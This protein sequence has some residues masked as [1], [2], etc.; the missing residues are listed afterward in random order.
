M[1]RD[2]F[3]RMVAAAY[4]HLY[5]MPFLRNHVLASLIVDETPGGEDAG[6]RLHRMLLDEIERLSPGQSAPVDSE[7]WR[8]YRLLY[9]HYVEGEDPQAVADVL[10]VTRRHFF[11][12]RKKALRVVADVLW[13]RFRDRIETVAMHEASEPVQ[14]QAL[15]LLRQ[16]AHRLTQ[17]RE[18]VHIP[19]MLAR[20]CRLCQSLADQRRVE[21][22]TEPAVNLPP[23]HINETILLHVLVGLVQREV[24]RPGVRMIR[25]S[26]EHTPESVSIN[27]HIHGGPADSTPETEAEVRDLREL[28]AMEGITLHHSEDAA[29]RA[30]HLHLPASSRATVL[31]VDDNLDFYH[32]FRRCLSGDGYQVI[33]PDDPREALRMALERQPDVITLDLM[34]PGVEGLSLLQRLRTLPETKDIPVIVCTVLAEKELAL[35]LGAAYYLPKPVTREAILAALSS[36][37]QR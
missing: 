6:W 18:I 23:V 25:L 24:R 30:I 13:E 15:A 28:G 5:D 1:S 35:S 22:R 14:E 12:L 8:R 34:M 31:V 7:P 27:V 9:H 11:R 16:E 33:A 21:I 2:E 3:R 32:F 20:V 4:A 29:Q 37:L 19:E 36:V 10:S 17:H 26:P